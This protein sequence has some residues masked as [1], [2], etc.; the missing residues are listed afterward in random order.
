MLI[1]PGGNGIRKK[2]TYTTQ[3]IVD[4][5]ESRPGDERVDYCYWMNPGQVGQAKGKKI[6]STLV[7]LVDIEPLE[8]ELVVDERQEQKKKEAAAWE[9]LAA[10]RK[11]SESM[12]V[13]E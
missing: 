12:G 2:R 4:D 7:R 6:R 11:L 10:A 3:E 13:C 5:L 8:S 9:K 1:L